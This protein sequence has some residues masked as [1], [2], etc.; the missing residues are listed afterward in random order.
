VNIVATPR[1]SWAAAGFAATRIA[2]VITAAP[3]AR[4]ECAATHSALPCLLS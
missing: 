2:A 4:L 3:A 1:G